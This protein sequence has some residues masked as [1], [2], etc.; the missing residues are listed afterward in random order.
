MK[1]GGQSQTTRS[2]TEK[3]TGFNHGNREE[4]EQRDLLKPDGGRVGVAELPS[5]RRDIVG[6]LDLAVAGLHPE[7]EAL[8]SKVRVA[9]PVHAPVPAHGHPLRV[10]PLD[11]GGG[12][13]AAPS[14]VGD[15]HQ[16]EVVLP[17]DGESDASAPLTLDPAKS[18]PHD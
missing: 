15:Q 8:T 3:M 11:P 6:G 16:L 2:F 17:V 7:G 10:G 13:D 1:V 12:D 18:T 5:R 4:V 9:L 14:H